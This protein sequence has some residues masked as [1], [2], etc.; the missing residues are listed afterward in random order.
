MDLFFPRERLLRIIFSWRR[1]LEIYFFLGKAFWN[2]FFFQGGLLSFIFFSWGR[3]FDIYFSWGRPFEIYFPVEGPPRFF[4]SISSGPP[5]RSLMVCF[6]AGPIEWMVVPNPA[7]FSFNLSLKRWS[8]LSKGSALKIQSYKL[9]HHPAVQGAQEEN[10]SCYVY[11]VCLDI[12]ISWWNCLVGSRFI[13]SNSIFI[14]HRVCGKMTSKSCWT[15]TEH[16]IHKPMQDHM[17]TPQQS[18]ALGHQIHHSQVLNKNLV[19]LGN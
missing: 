10:F 12:C 14:L 13:V 18:P 2:L 15:C 17:D 4:F 7:Q 8:I 11:N 1:P 19:E 5:P 9:F 3:P 6:C 16:A